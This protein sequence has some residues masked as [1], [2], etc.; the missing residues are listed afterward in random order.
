MV[1][2]P[3][4]DV[5]VIKQYSITLHV[6]FRGGAIQ[7]FKIPAPLDAW[8]RRRTAD[9]TVEEIDRLLD[10]HNCAEIAA[11]LNGKGL[12]TGT[13]MPFTACVVH[14]LIHGRICRAADNPDY[15]RGVT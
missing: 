14:R 8:H 12:Q 2:L 9:S 11:I 1:R 3:I 5:A 13:G 6:R 15:A 7:I 4:E 10:H